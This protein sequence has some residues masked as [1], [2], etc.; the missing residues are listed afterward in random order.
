MTT[1]MAMGTGPL[2]QPVWTARQT[3]PRTAMITIMA[4]ATITAMPAIPMNTM[5]T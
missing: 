3:L 1:P 5:P 2:R 4:M